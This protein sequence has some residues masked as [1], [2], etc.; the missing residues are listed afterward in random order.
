MS[1]PGQDIPNLLRRSGHTA[2]SWCDEKTLGYFFAFMER[3]RMG[4]VTSELDSPY[5]DGNTFLW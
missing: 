5:Y 1:W 4:H 3:D 2:I